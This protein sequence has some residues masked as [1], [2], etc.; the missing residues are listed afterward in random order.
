MRRA[1]IAVVLVALVALV[2]G[3]AAA[4]G[5]APC[6]PNAPGASI[7]NTFAWASR[8]S[9]GTPG[10]QLTYAINVFNNDSGCGSSTF[11]V[12]M[13][14]PDGFAVSVPSTVTVSS[15]S[16]T[17]VWAHVISPANAPDGDYPLTVTVERVGASSSAAPSYYK[18]YSTDAVGPK[19]YWMNPSDGGALSGRTAHV[20]FGSSDDHVVRQL[21]IF[22]DGALVGTKVCD[23]ITYDCH[24]SY[25]WSI[26]RVRGQHTA[27][28]ESTDAMGNVSTRTSTFTVN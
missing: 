9:W 14:A 13:S 22:V 8:G 17:Y 12:S 24:L 16:S 1:S 15:A 20:G 26:R 28:F 21:R 11:G 2:A 23:N 18:V 10:E 4:G 3:P 6:T 25:K 19:L 7:D 27:T 5:K